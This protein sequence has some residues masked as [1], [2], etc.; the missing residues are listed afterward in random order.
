L[1]NDYR[2]LDEPIREHL[3]AIFYRSKVSNAR[4]SPDEIWQELQSISPSFVPSDEIN[5]LL[6][7]WGAIIE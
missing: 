7:H 2:T 5:D 6:R 1:G 3:A 4:K